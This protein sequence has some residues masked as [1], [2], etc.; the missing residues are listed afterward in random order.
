M[1]CREFK[2]WVGDH[3]DGELAD[4]LK[5]EFDAHM[6]QCISCRKSYEAIARAWH[7]LGE[8]PVTQPSPAFV[9]R[10]WTKVASQDTGKENFAWGF[11]KM[12]VRHRLVPV[13]LTLSVALIIGSMGVLKKFSATGELSLLGSSDSEFIENIEL[14]EYLD[15]ISDM[16]WLQDME[17]IQDIDATQA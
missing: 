9:S 13:A 15:V 14:A 5:V 3:V 4:P 10:F 7:N 17:F 11:K 2:K 8:L 1:K 16:D 12:F 6:A